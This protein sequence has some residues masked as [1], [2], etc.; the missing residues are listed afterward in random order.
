MDHSLC[1]TDI[2]PLQTQTLRDT[3]TRTSRQKRERTFRL[4]QV[5]QY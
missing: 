5:K 3:Q 4:F 2:L 1:E